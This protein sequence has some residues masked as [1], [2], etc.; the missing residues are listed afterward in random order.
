[1]YLESYVSRV[2]DIYIYIYTY[3]YTY[4]YL[5]IIP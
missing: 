3:T 4:T 5:T 1:M 2:L